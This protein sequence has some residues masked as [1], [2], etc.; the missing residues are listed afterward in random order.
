M[1]HRIEKDSM[2]EL[3]VQESALWGAQTQRALENFPISTLKQNHAFIYSMAL[4][5]RSA[6]EVNRDLGLLDPKVADAII[7][8]AQEVMDDRHPEH[9]QLNPFQA[10]AGTSHNMN[11]N[12]VIA[13]RANQILGVPITEAKKPVN[14]NDHVNMAQSTNDTIP[15]AIRLGVLYRLDGLLTALDGLAD[16]LQAKAEEF[17]DIVKSGRTHL[18]DAVPIRMGQEFGGYAQAIRNDR[19]RIATAADRVRRLGIGGTAAGTGLNA[20]PE[21]HPRMIRRINELT[22][23]EVRSSGNLFESMQ[24]MA[25]IADYSAALNTLAVTLTRIANDFR[26]LASGPTTGLDEIRLPAVQ[27]GS[28]IMPGK[29]NPV[30]AEMLNMVCYHVMGSNLTVQLASAAGQLELNVMMPVIAYDLFTAVDIMTNAIQAFTTRCVVGIK[31]NREKAEGWLGKNVIIVTALNPVIGYLEGAA[32]AKEAMA[33][34][35]SVR[36]VA[37][38]KISRGELKHVNTGGSVSIEEIDSVLGDLRALTE[39]GVHGVG[40]GG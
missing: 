5:K 40:G 33:R 13:N 20:H 26:L 22:G 30:L 1:S 10:G 6:A 18:Q 19:E 25:D 17:D 35:L 7:Q 28:S 31:A 14:P 21:Y 29:V 24:S 8:A 23:F 38:E 12:E 34:N 15:T 37:L 9:F 27:P 16:A 39:G 4:L 3:R 36:E 11:I 32:I 2:G